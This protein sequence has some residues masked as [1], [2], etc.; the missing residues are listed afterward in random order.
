M[1]VPLFVQA[2]AE[3]VEK[4]SFH[5]LRKTQFTLTVKNRLPRGLQSWLSSLQHSKRG[6]KVTFSYNQ[7]CQTN[8]TFL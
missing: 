8:S 6:K 3:N 7:T 2:G 4:L 1:F 5:T